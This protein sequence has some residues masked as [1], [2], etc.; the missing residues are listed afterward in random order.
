MTMRTRIAVLVAAVA[1]V[2]AVPVAAQSGSDSWQF[3][4]A[5][6]LMA[7]GMEGTVTVKG[8]EIDVDV[9]FSAIADNL[10]MGGM[11]HFDMRNDRWLISSELIFMDLEDNQDVA[12]GAAKVSMQQTVF[13]VAG[14]YR[15]SPMVALLAGARWVD[16]SSG[17]AFTG[18]RVDESGDASKSWVDPF[19]GIHVTTPLAERWWLGLHGDLGGFG[20]GS[21]LAW[22]AYANLGFRASGSVSVILGYRALDMDY[23]AG[24]GRDLF[25][26]DILT[27]G[28]QVG[29]AFRF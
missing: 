19:V 27:A 29:V 13:E 23:E 1:A 12:D 15:V 4:L 16:L 6:Y 24:S 21:D 5:P 25:T 8:V 26:Y 22:Q 10:Q 3:T 2:A 20:V 28:P 9:P 17:L 14:G 7:A 18:A 11:V